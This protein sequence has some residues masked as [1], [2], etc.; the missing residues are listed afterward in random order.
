MQSIYSRRYWQRIYEKTESWTMAN[1]WSKLDTL[2]I[3]DTGEGTGATLDHSYLSPRSPVPDKYSAV[4]PHSVPGEQLVRGT[5]DHV[6]GRQKNIPKIIQQATKSLLGQAGIQN[7]DHQVVMARKD[8]ELSRHHIRKLLPHTL[9]AR[10]ELLN[11]DLKNGTFSRLPSRRKV[12]HSTLERQ[13]MTHEWTATN[14]AA[15]VADVPGDGDGDAAVVG[16]KDRVGAGVAD[17]A[18]PAPDVADVAAG[19]TGPPRSIQSVRLIVRP[20]RA[21]ST[22][23]PPTPTPSPPPRTE[24][25][26][27]APPLRRAVPTLLSVIAAH[28]ATVDPVAGASLQP[29]VRPP[30]APYAVPPVRP[31]PSVIPS[32]ESTPSTTVP[33]SQTRR[34]VPQ[35]GFRPS[36]Q[37]LATSGRDTGRASLGQARGGTHL[38]S[39]NTIWGGGRIQPRGSPV[40]G[41]GRAPTP[42]RGNGLVTMASQ[43]GGSMGAPSRDASLALPDQNA[44][45][46]AGEVVISL[47]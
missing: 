31:P 9:A 3:I 40:L 34:V 43:Y 8:V 30:I 19:A 6:R 37:L 25:S 45:S 46:T 20:P 47:D 1:P 32:R 12:S 13:T 15:G 10:R 7:H 41:M 44:R 26:P 35:T 24:L 27:P 42:M 22:P 18:A 4:C 2:L 28:D 23:P 14:S 36:V 17:V 11:R 29:R 21:P 5:R 38:G 39:T 33:P 16:G